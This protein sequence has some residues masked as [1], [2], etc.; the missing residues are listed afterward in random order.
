MLSE[1]GHDALIQWGPT[2]K[3][4]AGKSGLFLLQVFPEQPTGVL[5]FQKE[6]EVTTVFLERVGMDEDG[7][8][9]IIRKVAAGG[10]WILV[11]DGEN[12][13]LVELPPE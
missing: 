7:S 12:R 5:A 2:I 3:V 6:E 10:V 11:I 1:A 4:Q 9:E 13:T 8:K